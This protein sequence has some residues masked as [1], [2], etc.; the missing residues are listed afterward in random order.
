[1]TAEPIVGR[2]VVVA[3]ARARVGRR[4]AR[5]RAGGGAPAGAMSAL[6][7]MDST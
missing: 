4:I 3:R 2:S 6:S 5:M 1:M 7:A